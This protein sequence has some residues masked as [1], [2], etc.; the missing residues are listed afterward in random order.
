[1]ELRYDT[2]R[3]QFVAKELLTEAGIRTEYTKRNILNLGS[4]SPSIVYDWLLFAAN[5]KYFILDEQAAKFKHSDTLDDSLSSIKELINQISILLSITEH[6]KAIKLGTEINIQMIKE[7]S[8][9][10]DNM[11][12]DPERTLKNKSVILYLVYELLNNSTSLFKLS[13]VLEDSVFES[14]IDFSHIPVKLI[15]IVPY[16]A[17]KL[18]DTSLGELAQDFLIRQNYF[19]GLIPLSGQQ[20]ETLKKIEPEYNWLLREV[21]KL[22]Y[23]KLYKTLE[24]FKIYFGQFRNE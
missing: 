14:R 11:P 21:R 1:M 22:G 19:Q 13:K 2:G 20:R 4:L 3:V 7:L 9:W 16:I 17:V 24:G 23:D 10:V 5:K 15:I 8:R 6:A 18:L 12:P